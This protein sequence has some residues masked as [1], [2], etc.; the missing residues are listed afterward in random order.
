MNSCF[1]VY[2]RSVVDFVVNENLQTLLAL[3]GGDLCWN[4]RISES[5]LPYTDKELDRE[6][7]DRQ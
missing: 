3:R 7:R 4:I 2:N 6:L 1:R 5:P